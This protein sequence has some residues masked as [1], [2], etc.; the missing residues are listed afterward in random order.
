MESRGLSA[1][2]VNPQVNYSN[3]MFYFFLYLSSIFPF[4]FSFFFLI[5]FGVAGPSMFG[6]SRGFL[7]SSFNFPTTLVA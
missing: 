4:L 2:G 5:Q 1:E 6:L 3:Y 7:D